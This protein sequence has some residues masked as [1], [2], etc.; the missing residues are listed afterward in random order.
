M[1]AL[2]PVLC[3]SKKEAWAGDEKP[4]LSKAKWVDIAHANFYLTCPEFYLIDLT[5]FILN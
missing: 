2:S 4:T 3:K 5:E 1:S